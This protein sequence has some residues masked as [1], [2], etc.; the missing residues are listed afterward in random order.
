MRSAQSTEHSLDVMRCVWAG[1]R[2]DF[3]MTCVPHNTLFAYHAFYN[4]TIGVYTFILRTSL[5]QRKPMPLVSEGR[6]VFFPYETGL[7]D[8]H[9]TV[10]F[11]HN[12]LTFSHA[13]KF[14]S[15]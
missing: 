6:V 8:G 13:K 2:C 4:R 3:E 12:G 10:S 14:G 7:N 15:L 5:A 1:E 11:G 9:R